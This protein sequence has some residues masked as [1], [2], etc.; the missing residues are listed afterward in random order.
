MRG[1]LA[2]DPLWYKDAV[3]YELHVRAFNDS[4]GDGIGDFR[5]LTEKLDYLQDWASR[6]SGC[7]LSIPSPLRDDGYDIADYTDVHPAYGTLDDS[8]LSAR[9]PPPRPAGHHRAGAQSHLRPAPVVS[10]RAPGPGRPPLAGFLRLERH[11]REIPGRPH[12]LQGFRDL[13]L[14]LGPRGQGLLL[15]PLLLPSARLEFRQS[16]GPRGHVRGHGLL[17]RSGRGRPAAGRGALPLRA[18]RHQL[19]ESAGDARVPEGA[20]AHID[21]KY[22]DRMLLAEA[23]QWPEDAVGYFGSGDEC[24]M[25]FH[26]PSCRGCSWP[27][28]WRTAIPI[29]DILQQTPPI[30]DNCQWAIFLRNHDELTL[31]MVTDE[32]RDYM[33]RAYAHDP[34]CASIWASAAGS[35]RCWATTAGRSS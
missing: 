21:A 5:G 31:E 33:Y 6:R 15:A 34:R 11:A 24:H 22:H 14:G 27:C 3:I 26:F 10:A 13:Q 17:V 25:D 12:H 35:R 18:R 23:N 8:A 1:L 29:I 4:D 2:D 30:P 19:R 32:E 16:R 7:C 9:G 20:A 28:A